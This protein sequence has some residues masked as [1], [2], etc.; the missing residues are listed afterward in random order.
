MLHLIIANKLYSSW[1]LRPWIML[2]HLGVPFAETVIPLPWS[3]VNPPVNG[4]R[5]LIDS[6]SGPGAGDARSWRCSSHR[7]GS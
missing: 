4:L 7:A 1:S 5:V 6:A 2:R 3:G